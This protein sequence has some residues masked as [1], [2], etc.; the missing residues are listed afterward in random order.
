MFVAKVLQSLWARRAIVLVALLSTMAGGFYIWKTLPPRYAATSRVVLEVVK[1][2]PV[3]GQVLSSKTAEIYI[4]TQIELIR[5]YEVAGRVVDELGWPENPEFQAA[6]DTRTD[7][8]EMDIRRW[9]AQPIM[10]GTFATMVP[11]SNMLEI[12][13]RSTSPQ[14]AQV[15]ADAL[16]RA[17]IQASIERR[18]VASAAT[19]DWYDQQ[20][21][22]TKAAI[23]QLEATKTEFQR[24]TGVV[25]ELGQDL[26]TGVLRSVVL[27]P[28]KPMMAPRAV[29]LVAN[30]KLAALDSQISQLNR[31]LGPNHPALQEAQRR[32]A[33]LEVSA[34]AENAAVRNQSSQI[35]TQAR[36]YINRL[37][38]Q[39]A[40]VFSQREAL[41]QAQRIQD[42]LELL[43]A[44]FDGETARA[45]KLRQDAEIIDAG[46]A[47]LGAT[48][49]PTRAEFPNPP[50][51]MGGSMV[52]G[53]GVGVLLALLTELLGRKVRTADDLENATRAPVL[54]A[55]PPQRRRGTRLSKAASRRKPG[56]TIAGA[57][58]SAEGAL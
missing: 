52:L 9:A 39:T 3:T 58:V 56:P 42:E 27:S 41:A 7:G 14:N 4:R 44:Q 55:L 22:K 47:P 29:P 13:F 28:D 20:A 35:D 17:Y 26:E 16:R 2:D 1:P 51:I 19:A 5:D 34:A 10:N 43:R 23:V 48:N 40:K 12:S 46:V 30:E 49:L 15:I 53:L 25:I 32:R 37:G 50:L 11:D 38:T 18:Q 6:Y 24:R 57:D 8:S 33:A 31:T 45:A 21:A 36:A 54:A